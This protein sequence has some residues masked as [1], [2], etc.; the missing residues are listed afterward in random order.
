MLIGTC[1]C[2]S[3]YKSLNSS[4][5]Q[6]VALLK[7]YSLCRFPYTNLLRL[8]ANHSTHFNSKVASNN[9]LLLQTHR[10]FSTWRAMCAQSTGSIIHRGTVDPQLLA[11]PTSCWYFQA[12]LWNSERSRLELSHTCC[13]LYWAMMTWLDQSGRATFQPCNTI[14]WLRKPGDPVYRC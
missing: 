10:T 5:L 14:L 9:L 6:L 1:Y 7:F 12:A 2:W 3:R 8:H 13:P 4:L 11:I